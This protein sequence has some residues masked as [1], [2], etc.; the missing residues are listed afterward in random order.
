MNTYAAPV[1]FA[2]PM[3]IPGFDLDAATPLSAVGL[4]HYDELLLSAWPPN[5][6][7]TIGQPTPPLDPDVLANIKQK[8]FVGYAP[9]PGT[10][11][12]NQVCLSVCLFV[13]LVCLSVSS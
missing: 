12:R 1:E 2:P 11:K 10:T 7:Y 8:D 4:P 5:Q 9:N 13:C 3:E 6:T